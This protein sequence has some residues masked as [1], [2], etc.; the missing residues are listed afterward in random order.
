MQKPGRAPEI[1]ERVILFRIPRLW[2]PEMSA[3]ELYETTQGWWTLGRRR[4]GADYA[5]A[6][7]RGVIREVYRGGTPRP[8]SR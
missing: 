3:E 5:F 7:N 8:S 6:V 1:K 2:S 4:N